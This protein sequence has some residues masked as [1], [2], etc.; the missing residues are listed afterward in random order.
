MELTTKDWKEFRIGDLFDGLNGD[1]DIKQEHINNKGDIV[2]TSGVENFGI[3]GKTDVKARL[4]NE[5][6]LTIDMFGNVF[7]RP[8]KYKMVTH[9]RVFALIPKFDMSNSI[10]LFMATIFF[11]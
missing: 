2:I 11:I 1:F 9:A 7:Y 4:I 3:L 6:T 8:Y 10:G 5:K